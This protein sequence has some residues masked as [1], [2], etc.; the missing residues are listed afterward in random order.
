MKD[1]VIIS[2]SPGR[3]NWV[4]E[5][6][7]SISRPVIVVSDFGYE[8]GKIK[9]VFENTNCDRFLF[10]QDSLVIRDEALF[11]QVFEAK[12]SSCIMDIPA[13]L[14]SYMGVYER[15]VL[16][17]IDI[18]VIYTKEESIFF[19]IEWTQRYIKLCE[20]FS[21]PISIVHKELET[22]RKFG[23]ENLLYVN[24]YYE[25]WKGDWGVPVS[26]HEA[27]VNPIG[28]ERVNLQMLEKAR[29][30]Q[31]MIIE[32]ETLKRSTES[33]DLLKE[34]VA[35]LTNELRAKNAEIF[36][37]TESTIWKLFR[38]YRKILEK[39]RAH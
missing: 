30:I 6:L 23:R 19:E 26:N 22:V 34:D 32:N 2:T 12:G 27:I 10:L 28:L 3:E 1:L 39:I 4:K 31:S 17:K 14:G 21:H 5:M 29:V 11:D 25:K 18:P 24:Q 8:L 20:N 38:P 35:T 36:A 15:S 37:L 7:C 33:L 13:C 16:S 9:W